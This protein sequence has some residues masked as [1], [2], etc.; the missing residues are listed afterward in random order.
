MIPKALQIQHSRKLIRLISVLQRFYFSPT[1]LGTENLIV[2]K[3]AMYVGNHTLYGLLDAPILIDYLLHEHNIAVVT[4]ADHLHFHVP[5]WRDMVQRIGAIEGIPAYGRQAMQQGYSI[6]VFPGGT[7][8][9]V[10]R[11]G[12]A[13]QLI[14][15]QRYGFLKLAQ[16]FNYEIAPFIA[17]GGDEV[18]DIAFDANG[19]LHQPCFEKFLSY[20]KVGKLLRH[21]DII[22]PIPKSILPKRIPFYFKFLPRLKVQNIQ[23][24]DELVQFRAELQQQIYAEIAQLK[25]IRQQDTGIDSA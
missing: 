8:E 21:G 23:S 1:Y 6:L 14:W 18:F 5:L 11:K 13:Y 9:V 17:L 3:P 19:L 12:E 4:L 7:R 10:K 16:E 22:P 20:P 25:L 2:E 15:K 24:V